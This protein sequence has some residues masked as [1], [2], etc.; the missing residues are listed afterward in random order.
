[1]NG[2][3]KSKRIRGR[4]DHQNWKKSHIRKASLRRGMTC[5]G[6]QETHRGE[7]REINILSLPST[8]LPI[9]I[10]P[11]WHPIWSQKSQ[12]PTDKI[13]S[14]A[15]QAKTT[16]ESV[17]QED[18]T[19]VICHTGECTEVLGKIKSSPLGP[20]KRFPRAGIMKLKL[21]KWAEVSQAEERG[22]TDIPSKVIY[23]Y[24]DILQ[25]E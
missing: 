12:M 24:K 20:R 2:T 5:F 3:P 19:E 17:D 23:N 13:H 8:L 22:E 9:C 14:K 16:W 25:K 11:W 1:M 4:R 10:S 18:H 6:R 7:P 15:S 21:Y